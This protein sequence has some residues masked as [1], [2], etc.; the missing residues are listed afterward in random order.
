VIAGVVSGIVLLL[1]F[2][3]ILIFC[4]CRKK[5]VVK[6]DYGTGRGHQTEVVPPPYYSKG[7]ENKALE[8]NM[9]LMED[10]MKNFNHGQNGYITYNGHVP[11]GNGGNSKT[12]SCKSP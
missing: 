5:K 6:K 10:T 2:A 8:R 12:I 11:N 4:C 1:C 7:M 9:D 3:L